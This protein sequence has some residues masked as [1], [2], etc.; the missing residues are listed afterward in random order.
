MKG[1]GKFA[2]STKRQKNHKFKAG[3]K[4]EECFPGERERKVAAWQKKNASLPEV[5][6][7][8]KKKKKKF[9]QARQR[10]PE[11]N[12][13]RSLLLGDSKKEGSRLGLFSVSLSLSLS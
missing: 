7:L 4:S 8:K 6:L 9:P 11:S 12:N 5:R 10:A 13:N 1:S 3:G 2:R